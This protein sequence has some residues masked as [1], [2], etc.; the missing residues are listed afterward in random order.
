[1]SDV[2]FRERLW[3]SPAQAGQFL[4]VGRTR[5]FARIASGEILSRKDGAR[6]LCFVPSLLE[7]YGVETA[8]SIP[9]DEMEAPIAGDE[10]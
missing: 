7:R 9:R 6:R 10:Q 2:P 4:G 5:I 1:M 3:C 8:Q